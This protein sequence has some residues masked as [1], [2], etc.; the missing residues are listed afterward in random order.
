MVESFKSGFEPP[1]DV[2]FEDY[3]QAMKRTVS[4]TSL[5]NTK[6]SRE[7]PGVKAKSKLWP[8]IKNKNKVTMNEH[9][10][11]KSLLHP[12]VLQNITSCGAVSSPGA[13]FA[14]SGDL[15]GL[16]WRDITGPI[17][18][19]LMTFYLVAVEIYVFSVCSVCYSLGVDSVLNLYI[20]N[21]FF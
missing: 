7:K 18:F 9:L 1:G 5:S 21:R 13:H 14:L 17:M 2:E 8:F 4:E 12:N 15:Y 20:F 16:G 11:Q 10:T 6:E 19:V 3:G